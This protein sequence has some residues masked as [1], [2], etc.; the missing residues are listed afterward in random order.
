MKRIVFQ[1]VI[2]NGI[3]DPFSLQRKSGKKKMVVGI[4]EAES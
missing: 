3:H 2:R 4:F 1:Y